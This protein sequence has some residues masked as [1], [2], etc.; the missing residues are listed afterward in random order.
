MQPKNFQVRALDALS[1]YLEELSGQKDDTLKRIRVLKKSNNT[2]RADDKDYPRYTWNALQKQGRV[3]GTPYVSRSGSNEEPFPHVCLKVPTGGGKTLL[4]T[5]ALGRMKV[6][7]GLVLWMTPSRAI[8]KQTWQAFATRMHP[9]RQALE[10]ASGG[11]IKLLTKEDNISRFDPQNY[12]C[13]M[14]LMLQ[15][16]DR[17]ERN[18]LRLFRD[19]GKYPS[20]FPPQ[21]DSDANNKLITE[22]PDLDTYDMGDRG[23]PGMVKHS[24]YNLLKIAR[25]IIVLDEAHNAYSPNRRKKLSEFNPRFVLELSATPSSE[26]SNILVNIGGMELKEEQLIK[27]PLKVHN[28][29]SAD[30]QHTLAKSKEKLEELEA[31]AKKL[32]TETG[33]Y[34]RPIMLIRVQRVGKE[35]R[36][37]PEYIHAEDVRDYLIKELNVPPEFIR[38]KTAEKDEIADEDLLSPYSQVRYILTKDALREGWDCP[39]AY[40]LTLLD[41]TKAPLA[42]TQMTGRV[43]RQPGAETTSYKA[44]NQAYIYCFNQDVTAAL[45]KIKKGLEVEGLA[46]A[47]ELILGEPGGGTTRNEGELLEFSR[48]K[49]FKK[50]RVFLP[51]VLFKENK[52]TYRPI[53]YDADILSHLNPDN[54]LSARPNITR[55]ALDRINETVMQ[56]DLPGVLNTDASQGPAVAQEPEIT[57]E[58]FVR[59][60]ENMTLNAWTAAKFV[61]S[62]LKL[63]REDG[64]NDAWIFKRRYN[65][66]AAIKQQIADLL[67][68]E[69]KQIFTAKL[70]NGDIRFELTIDDHNYELPMEVRKLVGGADQPLSNVRAHF[71]KSLFED[72]YEHEFTSLEKAFALYINGDDAV[73]WWHRCG[74]KTRK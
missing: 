70:K 61:R 36:N 12:L 74:G 71:N 29:S 27:L 30:W 25:P 65:I 22:F 60:L 16:A 67:E 32:K 37:K 73:N 15:A 49:E 41:K 23:I 21:D 3:A 69:A 59:F 9:Y 8:Y 6:Q 42:L 50:L 57:A 43:L 18:F 45:N 56:V 66:A 5:L 1:H 52:K 10:R 24:L 31:T 17:E 34:I 11:K 64:K 48:R 35:Q 7:T 58:F 33:R 39:F 13:I 19:S 55:A 47:A 14:P 2:I 62:A 26:N 63:L 44:L 20:F 4:G 46:D 28:F 38:R 40:I 51:K 54:L 72:L 53:D 68:E